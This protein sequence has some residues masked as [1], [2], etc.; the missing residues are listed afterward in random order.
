MKCPE[1][2]T[3]DLMVIEMRVAGEPV[4]LRSCSSCGRRWWDGMEGPLDLPSIL[5]LAAER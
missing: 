1:C 4:T 3:H 2:R 5:A